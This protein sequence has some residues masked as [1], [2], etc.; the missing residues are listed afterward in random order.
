[1]SEVQKDVVRIALATAFVFVVLG[2]FFYL[3]IATPVFKKELSPD[4]AKSLSEQYLQLADTDV[5]MFAQQ[6]A[7]F[8]R[9]KENEIRTMV[10]TSEFAN[11]TNVTVEEITDHVLLGGLDEKSISQVTGT[12]TCGD[13]SDTQNFHLEFMYNKKVSTW[14]ISNF[15][16]AGC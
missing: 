14:Q 2:I 10:T 9:V 6:L 11:P 4:L 16:V 12:Y 7:D 8:S 3:A 1:M 15:Y 13:S 5:P